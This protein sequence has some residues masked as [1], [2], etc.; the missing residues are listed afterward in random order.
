MMLYYTGYGFYYATEREREKLS[1]H[2]SNELILLFFAAGSDAKI[3]G[4]GG[5]SNSL[6]GAVG[7]GTCRRFSGPGSPL[8]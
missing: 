5:V 6:Q 7:T 1:S 4:Y 2:R 8:L 3:A